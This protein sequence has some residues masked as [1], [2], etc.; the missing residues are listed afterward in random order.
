MEEELKDRYGPV[1]QPLDNLLR[2]IGLKVLLAGMKMK[3]LEY[4]GN[5]II[6]HVTDRTPLDMK[7]IVKM[8]KEG[9]GRVKLLPD[10]RI[11]IQEREEPEDIVKRGEKYVDAPCGGM[12]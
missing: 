4:A 6:L 3:R 10:G 1:P 11:V 8:V 9:K 7:K 2:I 12:I 5:Q